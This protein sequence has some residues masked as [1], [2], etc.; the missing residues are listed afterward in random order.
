MKENILKQIKNE[1]NDLRKIET[2]LNKDEWNGDPYW[3]KVLKRNRKLQKCK[4]KVLK[5]E[6][7]CIDKFNSCK[8]KV[9]NY[10]N[11]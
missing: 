6:V 1:E 8:K 5:A 10:I 2:A 11:K 7:K 3:T 4:I 9:K